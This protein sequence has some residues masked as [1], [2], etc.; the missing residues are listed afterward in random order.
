MVHTRLI[1]P[2]I[3]RISWLQNI[4]IE[5]L[6]MNVL[7]IKHIFWTLFIGSQAFLACYFTSLAFISWNASPKVTS[8]DLMPIKE[9]PFPAVT[10]CAPIEGK[11]LAVAKALDQS[12]TNNDVFSSTM[13]GSYTILEKF[14]ASLWIGM[15]TIRAEEAGDAYLGQRGWERFLKLK[16]EMSPIDIKMA[17]MLH[18]IL[19]S[20]Y[21]ESKEG[22]DF[23]ITTSLQ[24]LHLRLNNSLSPDEMITYLCEFTNCSMSWNSIKVC[25]NVNKNTTVGQ[26]CYICIRKRFVLTLACLNQDLKRIFLGFLMGYKTLGTIESSRLSAIHMLINIK[27]DMHTCL[28]PPALVGIEC[29]TGWEFKARAIFANYMKQFTFNGTDL[30]LSDVWDIGHANLNTIGRLDSDGQ[31][32]LKT[33]Q[34]CFQ[35]HNTTLCDELQTMTNILKTEFVDVFRQPPVHLE[36]GAT[37]AL[38][39]LCKYGYTVE[40][41]DFETCKL[42]ENAQIPT[43]ESNCYTFN[44]LTMNVKYGKK[45]SPILGLTF[46]LDMLTVTPESIKETPAKMILHEP[47]V[48]PDTKHFQTTFLDI[49]PGFETTITLRYYT[50]ILCSPVLLS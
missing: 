19:Y 1:A 10:I 2:G 12:D 18:F 30:I 23:L 37:S 50:Y 49:L 9:I 32:V 8:V 11:W 44:G 21:S 27:F 5:S 31:I 47:G 29:F 13:M 48:A 17:M 28:G 22:M 34:G 20:D 35:D 39:P 7:T 4:E 16:Y 25:D 6:N 38:I 43:I 26:W 15:H 46:V 36:E 40:P 24:A 3:P 41:I 14:W 33:T 42:F 45:V